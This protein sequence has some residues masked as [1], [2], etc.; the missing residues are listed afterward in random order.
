MPLGFMRTP[1]RGVPWRPGGP[2]LEGGSG[3]GGGNMRPPMAP[4]APPPAA[5][6][7]P[8]GFRF[9][10]SRRPWSPS[11]GLMEELAKKTRQMDM[12][13]TDNPN[14]WDMFGPWYSPPA[15]WQVPGGWTKCATPNCDG[16]PTHG[17]WSAGSTCG[18]LPPCPPGQAGG[19]WGSTRLPWGTAHATRLNVT[20]YIW[21]SGSEFDATFRG[22]I[23]AQ[24]VRASAAVV[25]MPQYK[26]GFAQPLPDPAADPFADPFMQPAVREKQYSGTRPAVMAPPYTVPAVEYGPS[27]P[28]GTPVDVPVVPPPRGTHEKKGLVIT[29]GRVGRAYG[30]LTEF[31]DM[32]DCVAKSIPGN[33]CK[34]LTMHEKVACVA[35]HGRKIDVAKAATCIMMDAAQDA[36]IGKFNRAVR[37]AATRNPYWKRPVGPGAGG[38]AARYYGSPKMPRM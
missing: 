35:K 28:G 8:R 33:P 30:A 37:E 17:I 6:K 7:N 34:G 12:D 38:W 26:V 1:P 5:P 22:T 16:A 18:A 11:K 13:P 32:L 31:G 14:P 21:T 24:F 2:L 15:G 3:G 19:V 27:T 10:K 29:A 20:A 23:V 25:A 4:P 36:A 9:P